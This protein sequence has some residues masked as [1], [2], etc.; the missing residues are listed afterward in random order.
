MAW[1]IN[2][3]TNEWM[4]L[5]IDSDYLAFQLLMRKYCHIFV[6]AMYL[7]INLKAH[8]STY[9]VSICHFN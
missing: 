4:N 5:W 1:Y 9:L 7:T 2:Q 8:L 3:T 6:K